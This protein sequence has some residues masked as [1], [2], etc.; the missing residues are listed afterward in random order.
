MLILNVKIFQ[1]RQISSGTILSTKK[2]DC[3]T[4]KKIRSNISPTNISRKWE[5]KFKKR[6][7]GSSDK[8]RNKICKNISKEFIISQDLGF[9]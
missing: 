1:H 2:F 6:K 8:E 7:Q 3:R 5:V 4:L 9:I